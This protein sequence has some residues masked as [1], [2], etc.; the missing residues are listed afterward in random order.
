M[1]IKTQTSAGHAASQKVWDFYQ[2]ALKK[3]EAA[4]VKK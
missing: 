2:A 4:R 1:H 3:Q